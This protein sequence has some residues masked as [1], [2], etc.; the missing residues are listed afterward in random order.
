M[1]TLTGVVTEPSVAATVYTS[2]WSQDLTRAALSTLTA[3]KHQLEDAWVDTFLL[4]LDDALNPELNA[5]MDELDAKV[6]AIAENIE[7]LRRTL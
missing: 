3:K 4:F 5:R 1:S 7:Q 6:A 2:V